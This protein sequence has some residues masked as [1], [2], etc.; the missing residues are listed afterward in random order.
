V[1]LFRASVLTLARDLGYVEPPYDLRLRLMQ[2]NGV[3][4]R[5]ESGD[6]D[7]ILGM[8][9]LAVWVAVD[10]YGFVKA[11][12]RY[13][14]NIEV[15]LPIAIAQV[16][17]VTV[18]GILWWRFNTTYRI[19]SGHIIALT[20]GGKERWSESIP[21]LQSVAIVKRRWRNDRWLYLKWPGKSR[22]IELFDT[23]AAEL[24]VQSA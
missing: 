19:E 1:S 5:S 23:L 14:Y 17:L 22:H 24:H 3:F 16:L 10:A 11:T 12:S 15:W 6:S 13:G 2:I 4:R 20:R 18:L 7:L 21:A 8:V 9:V